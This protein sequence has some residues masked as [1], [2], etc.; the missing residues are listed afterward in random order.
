MRFSFFPR[1][2]G[3][4]VGRK[5]PEL[6]LCRSGKWR[7]LGKAGRRRRYVALL[8]VTLSA[9]HL[10]SVWM[11]DDRIPVDFKPSLQGRGMSRFQES[12]QAY[13]PLG[14]I[15]DLDVAEV[16]EKQ[17]NAMASGN[18]CPAKPNAPVFLVLTTIPSRSNS[19][20]ALITMLLQQ[21]FPVHILL[22]IPNEY[23]RFSA[24][25]AEDLNALAVS[26]SVS[27]S[28][29]VH[30]LHGDDFGPASK[31]L[32]PLS[33]LKG[34]EANIVVI[35]DDQV[36]APT[37]VCDLLVVGASYP[38]QA[39]TRRSRIFPKKHCSNYLT[40]SLLSEET[41]TPGQPRIIH[42]SDL[43]MGTSGYL[44]KTAFFDD[45]VF[46]YDDCPSGVQEAVFRNDDIW[47]S[48]HLKRRKV[49]VVV[50]LSGFR[51]SSTYVTGLP[52]VQRLNNGFS[53]LWAEQ[54]P[55]G[56]LRRTALNAFFWEFLL[57]HAE[58]LARM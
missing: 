31:L 23:K 51:F 2:L 15:G 37:L 7:N 43:V 50:S 8:M 45:S 53:G 48:G 30:L 54:I 29:R 17:Q 33:R 38:T 24:E 58:H 34:F 18:E 25:E 47:F 55:R 21:T 11:N 22:A 14:V 39:I 19:L 1:L 32:F 35:D 40:S 49:G 3:I 12:D 41:V 4:F 36:Y 9:L 57:A 6:E 27:S 42:D 56:D 20:A 5:A 52:E 28:Q 46:G 16:W 26:P 44:V 13:G 10:V